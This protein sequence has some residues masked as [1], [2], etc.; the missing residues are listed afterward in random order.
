ME[1]VLHEDVEGQVGRQPAV[2]DVVVLD[3]RIR[4][5]LVLAEAAE[6]LEDRGARQR[7]HEIVSRGLV[8]DVEDRVDELEV[9]RRADGA[10]GVG[11]RHLESEE[12]AHFRG[13]PAVE[14]EHRSRLAAAE[15]ALHDRIDALVLGAAQSR[16]LVAGR[17]VPGSRERLRRRVREAQRTRRVVFE[18]VHHRRRRR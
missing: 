4:D 8:V 16:A 12:R 5:V 11:R 14:V 2:R 6:P 9:L 7:S 3:D 1:L 17:L 10:L 18:R 13:G 15:V